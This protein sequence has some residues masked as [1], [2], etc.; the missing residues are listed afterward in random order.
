[1]NNRKSNSNMNDNSNSNGLLGPRGSLVSGTKAVLETW[2]KVF[3]FSNSNQVQ[4][5]W[6]DKKKVEGGGGCKL[7]LLC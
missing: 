5:K 2:G 1:M 6:R 3:H 7:Y 4:E